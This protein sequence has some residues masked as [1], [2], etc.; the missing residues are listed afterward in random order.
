M[1]LNMENFNDDIYIIDLSYA[2]S[3]SDMVFEL[4]SI[5][6]NSMAKNQKVALKLGNVDLNQSQLLSICS[7]ISSINSSVDYLETDSAQTQLAATNLGI[8]VSTVKT[9]NV[10]TKNEIELD[11]P[12]LV[13]SY[14]YVKL[15]DHLDIEEAEEKEAEEKEEEEAEE[16]LVQDERIE[17]FAQNPVLSAEGHHYRHE[18]GADL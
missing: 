5:L 13:P 4:S 17:D 9:N 12:T 18:H 11:E 2:T 6:D 10:T 14:E 15:E 1:C 8:V 16:I 3:A 7:L